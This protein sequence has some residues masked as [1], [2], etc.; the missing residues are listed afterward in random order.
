MK[1]KD[2]IYNCLSCNSIIPFKGYTYQHKYCDNKCQRDLQSKLILEKNIELFN[3][4]KLANRPA[5]RR[6][7]SHLYGEKCFECDLTDWQ[8]KSIVLQ[9]DHINGEPYNNSPENL[10]LLCPNCHSQTDSFAGGNVGKGR[11][12]KENLARYYPKM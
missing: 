10:R 9:V 12:S 8:N 7:L 11:W 6:V 2:I 3:E 4:G 1:K 5:I